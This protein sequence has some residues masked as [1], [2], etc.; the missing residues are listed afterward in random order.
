MLTPRRRSLVRSAGLIMAALVVAAVT[1][2]G[3]ELPLSA[4]AA[5]IAS[6]ASAGGSGSYD[7]EDGALDGWAVDYGPVTLANSTAVAFSGTHSLAL[8]LT[9]T[10]NPGVR[11]PLSP[12]GVISG[13]V[14]SFH[15]YEPAG[16]SLSASVYSVDGNWNYAFAPLASLNSGGWT[17]LTLTVP[18]LQN[19]LRYFGLEIENGGGTKA[20]LAVDGVSWGSTTTTS[21]STTTS[22][23][24]T[25]SS[26]TTTSPT[27]TT[28]SSTTTSPT[29]TTSSSTST[30][31]SGT[32]N[33]DFEDGALDGWG[34]D[35]GPATLANSTAVAFSGAHSLA[36][37]LTGGGNPGVVSPAGPAG[38]TSGT[39]VT[40]HVYEPTGVTLT[41]RAYTVDGSWRYTF[42]PA[43]TLSPG[44]WAALSITVPALQNGLRF[45][46]IEIENGGGI[47]TTLYLDAVG[48]GATTTTSSSTSTSSSTT[49]SSTT[50]SATTT[51][52]T[53]TS[54]TTSS[55]PPGKALI[56][57]ATSES[58]GGTQVGTTTVLGVTFNEPPRLGS[59][60]GLT[61]TDGTHTATLQSSDGSL[62]AS[63]SGDTAT[64][65][66]KKATSLSLSVLEILA[67]SGVTDGSGNAWNLLLS[68][69]INKSSATAAC[70]TIGVTRVFGGD[71]CSIGFGAAG[72]TSP[73]V[74]DVIPL[75]TTD[76][77]GPPDDNAP[78][79]I[80][81]CDA[82]STDTVYD[83]NLQVQLGANPC[84]NNPPEQLIGNTNSNTLDYIPTPN[85]KS[86]SEAGVTETIPG[87]SY[88][89][90]TAIPPQ[91]SAIS[92]SGSGATFTYYEPV[93][94]QA[95]SSDGPTW[96]QFTYETP[97]AN[98]APSGLV[99]P[100]GI[101]CPPA[102]GGASLTVT[103]GGQVPFAAGVRFKYTGYGAGHYIVGAPGTAF[104][105][106]RE[107]SESAYAGPSSLGP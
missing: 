62:S 4:A 38:V 83:V 61:L 59:S 8:T 58:G 34:V 28:S 96:S 37:N 51:S 67:S 86:F 32:W 27:T 9:G 31:G 84:G 91:L 3:V 64:F 79:T 49:T 1:W 104:A 16:A 24:T 6:A 53:T 87:S 12:A 54:S 13:T 46:G 41:A 10:G 39:V 65:T 40:Y 42:A 11:S 50:S 107:A 55:P 105:A 80:T 102:A 70:A 75:P 57:T 29:T 85:L 5:P 25:T 7:F 26:S 43:V 71:D 100:I 97:Y 95:S 82:G 103:Y 73:S 36:M 93:S 22:P 66:V 90:A 48:W 52:S 60:Y 19:G 68:G 2:V 56:A 72:P 81:N 45:F 77:S 47:K 63:I 21:S 101:A 106:E 20:T 44:R 98:L 17:T 69:Q 92:V 99:Y 74:Y 23:T 76:L 88:I 94:C 35:Y 14:L 78:E 15:V 33:Y 89:S 18:A 30:S